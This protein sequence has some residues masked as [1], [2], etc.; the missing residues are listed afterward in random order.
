V[1]V[2]KGRGLGQL[3]KTAIMYMGRGTRPG[4]LRS[5]RSAIAVTVAQKSDLFGNVYVVARIVLA[6]LSRQASREFQL[7][8]A[9]SRGG[10]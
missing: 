6:Q 4:F 3:A 2:A 5:K 9:Q 8:P 10:S 1:N 7:K